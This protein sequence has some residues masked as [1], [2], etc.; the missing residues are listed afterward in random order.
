MTLASNR[1]SGITLRA[2]SNTIGGSAATSGNFIAHNG[3]DGVVLVNFSATPTSTVIQNNTID[4]NLAHGIDIQQGNSTTIGNG[5]GRIAFLYNTVIH[6]AKEYSGSSQA[7]IAAFD[8]S[9][10][11]ID[12]I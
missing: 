4:S 7:E 6:V 3:G 1:G 2:P 12:A 5:G 10:D 9:D 8:W 11:N